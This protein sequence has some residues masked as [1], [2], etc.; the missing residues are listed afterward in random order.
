MDGNLKRLNASNS[1]PNKTGLT[2]AY[3]H[4]RYEVTMGSWQEEICP[5]NAHS[6]FVGE[7]GETLT[8]AA[9]KGRFASVETVRRARRFLVFEEIS[10]TRLTE[11]G[12]L[13][14]IPVCL[15]TDLVFCKA[16]PTQFGCLMFEN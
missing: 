12:S 13:A 7:H 5:Y 10:E 14:N 2:E 11:L 6:S 9:D 4:L 1:P 15:R 3:L 8:R 16:I